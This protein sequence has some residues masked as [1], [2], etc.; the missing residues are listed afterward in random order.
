MKYKSFIKKQS[1]QGFCKKGVKKIPQNLPKNTCVGVS[2]KQ[3]FRSEA[4]NVIKKKN[5]SQAFSGKF[6][7]I[8]KKT[9]FTE[10]VRNF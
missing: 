6:C 8:S 7:E 2:F 5:P 10:H 9:F 4:C 1:P 3:S